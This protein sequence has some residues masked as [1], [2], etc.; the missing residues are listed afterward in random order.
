M[1]T[2]SETREFLARLDVAPD[3]DDRFTGTCHPAWP[4]RAFGGQVVAKALTA[5]AR[6]APDAAMAPLS[7]HAYFHAPVDA[8]EVADYAVERVKDGRTFATRRVAVTQDGRLRTT[9]VALLGAPGAGPDHQGTAP[10]VPSPGV[11]PPE[12]RLI[13]EVM[14]PRDADFEAMGYPADGRVDLR[15]VDQALSSAGTRRPTWMRV[16]VD[17]PDDP[18]TGAALLCYLSDITLGTT[19]LQ[20]HG[21]R[22]AT[23]DLQLGA[24]EISLW[25]ARPAPTREWM[26]FDFST[27]AAGGGRALAHG[28]IHDAE[29]DVLAVAVQNALLR[30]A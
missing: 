19:A 30:S 20:P 24:L 12:D 2:P 5:A 11:L 8:G 29:G 1:S 28:V 6:T 4:G 21:G 17:L 25:F 18:L 13:P 16:T 23:T 14:L 27:P 9:V 15:V 3:G 22:E 26:L 7:V 10:V